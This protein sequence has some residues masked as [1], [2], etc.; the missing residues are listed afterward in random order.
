MEQKICNKCNNTL[1]L[2]YFDKEG[3][4][5]RNSCKK[6]RYESLKKSR[7]EKRNLN[8]NNTIVITNK[9]CITCKKTKP[10]NDY[11]KLSTT[12]DGFCNY[13]RECTSLNRKK[14]IVE[15]Q[16]QVIITRKICNTCNVEKAVSEFKP[17]NKSQDGYFHKCI[18]CL[19]PIEWNKDKQKASEKKYVENNPDKIKKK[20]RRQSQ[21]PN[22]KLRSRL[23]Q[24]IKDALNSLSLR[25]DNKTMEYVGCTHEFIKSWFEYLFV[26]GMSWDNMKEW[27]IDHVSPC[28]SFDLTNVEDVKTCFNWKNLRPCWALENLEKSSH[29]I[30]EV[31]ENHKIKVNNFIKQPTTKPA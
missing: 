16:N 8:N 3:D 7:E 20:N 21:N 22:R 9:E 11:N 18:S 25:K 13:C 30:S 29:I 27:H 24:R 23:N 2:L 19:K 10:I 28:V 17:T 31:I 26:D 5:Y 6:C 12:N 14:P 4:R 1:S 15:K